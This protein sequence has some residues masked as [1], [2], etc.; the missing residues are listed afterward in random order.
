[1]IDRAEIWVA[2]GDGGSGVVSFRREKFAPRGGPDGGDGGIGGSVV[3]L[4]DASF[5]TLWDVGRRRHWR[6]ER[7]QHGR[8]SDMH[9]RRGKDLVIRVPVGTEVRCR[10]EGGDLALVGDL[11]EAGQTLV[12]ARG[13]LGGRGNARFA[14]ST[15]QAPRIAQRGQKGQEARLVLDLKLLSD[16]GILGVPN[17]GKSTLLAII[18]AAHPRIA[19]YPFTTVEPVLGVVEMGYTSFVVAEIPGL[20]EGAHRGVGLGH[21][22]LRHAERARMFVHLLDGTRPDPLQD[23]DVINGELAQFR[24]DLAAKAQ[25]VAVNKIDLP[26]VAQRTGELS[27]LL[28]ARQI[29]P[30]FISAA[31]GQGVGQLLERIVQEL[32]TLVEEAEL[33]PSLPVVRPR[34]LS[35]RF[36]VSVSNDVYRVSGERAEAFAEMMPL[37][38]DEGRAEFWRRLTRW[39]IVAA[40]KRAGIEPGAKVRLGETEVEWEG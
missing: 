2:A 39:G 27:E 9:G 28:T 33:P 32:S 6:G 17:A 23:M 37:D 14:T 1:M 40:L 8:G 36:S 30:F 34:P 18:S 21:D 35:G 20:I 31:T 16:V 25:V 13:G 24:E 10:S 5:R 4:A 3:L 15:N 12:V 29:E 7:G 38:Q 19:S 26:D 11:T 22:F